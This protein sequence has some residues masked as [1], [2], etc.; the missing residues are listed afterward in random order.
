MSD[1]TSTVVTTMRSRTWSWVV[2][3]ILSVSTLVRFYLLTNASIWS[4]EGFSLELI[5]Y[6]LTDIWKLSGRDVHPPLFYMLLHGWVAL[7]GSNAL[8]WTR[9]FSAVLGIVNVGLGI[10]LARMVSTPR[11]A[12]TAGWLLALLPIAVRTS[13]DIRMYALMGVELTGA[14]IALVYWVGKPKKN[15]YLVIYALLMLSGLYTH[16]FSI[17]C[18]LSHWLYLLLIRLPARG[19]YRHIESP[20]WWLAN[21][22]IAVL[23]LPWLSSSLA[24]LST[25]GVGWIQPVSSYSLPSAIWRFLT[26]N[27]GRGGNTLVYWLV[28]ILYLAGGSVV[29]C[30]DRSRHSV[31]TLIVICGFLTVLV[32]FLFSFYIPVFVERYLFFSAVMMPIVMAMVLDKLRN[33]WAFFMAVCALSAVEVLGLGYLYKQQHTMNNPYE[34]A[35][36]RLVELMAYFGEKSIDGDTLIVGDAYLF[37]AGNFYN[38]K[39]RKLLL[40]YSP[41]TYDR[42]N[43]SGFFAPMMKY[44]DDTFVESLDRVDTS[45]GRVWWLDYSDKESDEEADIPRRWHQVQ[46]LSMGD[47]V[48]K[49]YQICAKA[50]ADNS[51]KCE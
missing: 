7:I 33:Q 14:T 26:V 31:Q 30:K 49:L 23:Y 19:A 36:N 25:F 22:M 10:W 43:P 46:Q 39:H 17:F 32:V 35:D 41:S 4:D 37:Y 15:I 45:T 48:M 42:A 29:M 24:Q 34:V 18:A 6:P 51:I 47:N 1:L 50:K 44:G 28:P 3:A 13:Q 11:A 38:D 27:D 5:A 40:Y 20:R 21:L 16:Y 9:G 2:V 8:I 12:I